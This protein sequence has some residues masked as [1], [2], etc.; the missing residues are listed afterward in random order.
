MSVASRSKNKST[1]SE[2]RR[3]ERGEMKFAGRKNG[4]E[5]TKKSML[6]YA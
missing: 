3:K 2:N 5:T 6:P 4:G 1:I